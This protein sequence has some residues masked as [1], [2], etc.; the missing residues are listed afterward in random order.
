VEWAGLP[1]QSRPFVIVKR[2]IAQ[3][4]I[5]RLAVTGGYVPAQAALRIDGARAKK[6]RRERNLCQ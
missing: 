1:M 2:I 4:G 3:E 6:I 5:Y